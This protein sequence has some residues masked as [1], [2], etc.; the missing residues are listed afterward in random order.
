MRSLR[1]LRNLEVLTADFNHFDTDERFDRV[2]SVE[3]FEHLRNWPR[4]FAQVARWLNPGGRF[5]MHVFVHREAPYAFEVAALDM[6]KIPRRPVGARQR[7][8]L[9][10]ESP[11]T[12]SRASSTPRPWVTSRTRCSKSSRR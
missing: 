6:P 9:R 12:A 2:V 8:L 3:M 4:A 7:Q 5:F 1:G 11:P 10:H